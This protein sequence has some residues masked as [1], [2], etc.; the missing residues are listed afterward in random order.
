MLVTESV[1]NYRGENSPLHNAFLDEGDSRMKGIQVCTNY[2]R[3]LNSLAQAYVLGMW[4]IG[5]M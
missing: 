3:L 4:S 5:L 1:E 2:M